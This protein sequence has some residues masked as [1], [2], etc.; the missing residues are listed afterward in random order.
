MRAAA[1]SRRLVLVFRN[2]QPPKR[3]ALS[4]M[5][6]PF[7]DAGKGQARSRVRN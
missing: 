4:E 3:G 7:A 2:R 6:A 1:T 5:R